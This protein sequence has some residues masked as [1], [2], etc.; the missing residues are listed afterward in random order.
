MGHRARRP[1]A[2][3][4]EVVAALLALEMVPVED[5]LREATGRPYY[6]RF[7]GGARAAWQAFT[8]AAAD[9]ANGLP[10]G[11]A[12]RGVLSK[13]KHYVVRF[14]ALFHCLEAV[15]AGRSSEAPVGE[16]SVRRAVRTV[17]YFEAQ[18]RRCLGAGAGDP[19]RPAAAPGGRVLGG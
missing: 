17:W 8:R 19:G 1:G 13:L 9:R 7:D 15:C 6:A 3:Y 5:P 18:G 11:D 14:A 12:Y 16:A 4:A 2:G 10:A